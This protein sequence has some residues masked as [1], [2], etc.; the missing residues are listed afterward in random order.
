M[1]QDLCAAACRDLRV[2]LA[3]RTSPTVE[4]T[5]RCRASR[6]YGVG[7]LLVLGRI[8]DDAFVKSSTTYTC[9]LTGLKGDIEVD[10]R[11]K[12]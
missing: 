1:V 2:S 9:A 4:R 5:C 8:G 6:V 7:G 10:T 12:R 11:P 3:G